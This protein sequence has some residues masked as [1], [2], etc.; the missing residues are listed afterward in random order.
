MSDRYLTEGEEVRLAFRAHWRSGL[1]GILVAVGLGVAGF[2]AGF[3]L[4]DQRFIWGGL[5]G[6]VAGVF[7]AG[8]ITSKSVIEWLTTRYRVTTHR[9]VVRTG[10]FTTTRR[11]I[12]I[13]AINS[14]GVRQNAIERL[15]GFGDMAVESAGANSLTTFKNIPKPTEV[16]QAIYSAREERT[17]FLSGTAPAAAPAPADPYAALSSLADLR[18]RG[19]ITDAEFEAEK[20]KV[21]GTSE[22]AEPSEEA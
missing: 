1:L 22:P 6:I 20:A 13:D 18:D 8:L 16:K 5:I 11:E 21:L 14:V 10:L 4:D 17:R 19:A 2:F 3:Y 9:L 15:L 7:L 12:P